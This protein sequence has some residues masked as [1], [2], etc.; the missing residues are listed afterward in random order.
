MHR[1]LS[2]LWNVDGRVSS[3][4]DLRILFFMHRPV[5]RKYATEVAHGPRSE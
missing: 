2:F 5:Q 1:I 3:E 4:E